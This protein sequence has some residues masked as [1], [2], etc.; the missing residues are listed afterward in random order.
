MITFWC[1]HSW[2]LTLTPFSDSLADCIVLNL[3]VNIL[4]PCHHP[5]LILHF[6]C[7]L[8]S[9]TIQDS[10][11]LTIP[12]CSP[13]LTTLTWW[14]WAPEPSLQDILIFF[15]SLSLFQQGSQISWPHLCLSFG[16][17]SSP[18]PKLSSLCNEKQQKN[19]QHKPRKQL[20]QHFPSCLW[21]LKG[22]LL[23]VVFFLFF[24]FFIV[25]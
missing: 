16:N 22:S 21:F 10:P 15:P 7:V 9:L 20:T 18:S 14:L 2:I 12:P 19:S 25:F 24:L 6:M 13:F 3:L 1:T 4:T 11:P 17:L 5:S 8:P 23:V